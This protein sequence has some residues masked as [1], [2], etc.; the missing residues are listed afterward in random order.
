[1]LQLESQTLNDLSRTFDEL[2]KC[3]G[4]LIKRKDLE[5]IDKITPIANGLGNLLIGIIER[6]VRESSP[7]MDAL[8][9]FRD[10]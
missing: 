8:N 3:L 10:E 1:M 4:W 6:N 2:N 9:K 5:A 7:V